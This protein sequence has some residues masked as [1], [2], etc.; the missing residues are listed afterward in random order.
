MPSLHEEMGESGV[1]IRQHSPTLP[2][3]KLQFAMPSVQSQLGNSKVSS[4]AMQTNRP[5][6]RT[7]AAS[8]KG[9]VENRNPKELL[10]GPTLPAR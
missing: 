1:G 7:N 2:T 8:L 10:F 5:R 3:R 9:T 4:L 6:R